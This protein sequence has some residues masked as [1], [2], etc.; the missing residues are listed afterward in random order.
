M[1]GVIA[2]SGCTQADFARSIDL[3]PTKLSKAL[4]GTRRFTPLE[5]ALIAEQG[6]R[7]VDWLLYGASERPTLAARVQEADVSDAAQQACA[8][9]EELDAVYVTLAA[10]GCARQA[11]AL[12]RTRLRGRLSTRAP[13]SQQTRLSS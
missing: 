9:A 1:R 11:P 3:D 2:A 6:R 4:A 10:A 5:L 7:S 12:P 8:R 13:R